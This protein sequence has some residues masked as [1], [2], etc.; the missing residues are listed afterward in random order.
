MFISAAL[1]QVAF[2]PGAASA[3][4][5]S[6][7]RSFGVPKVGNSSRKNSIDLDDAE[8]EEFI[9]PVNVEEYGKLFDEKSEDGVAEA[10]VDTNAA[11]V[12]STKKDYKEPWV[13]FLSLSLLTYCIQR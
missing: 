2:G 9:S 7:I 11:M 5:S 12:A 10:S 13:I 4:S 6:S 8:D 1:V 3:S